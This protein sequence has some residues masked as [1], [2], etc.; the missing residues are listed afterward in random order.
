MTRKQILHRLL[1][2]A[3]VFIILSGILIWFLMGVHI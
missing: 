1:I 2:V 3:G